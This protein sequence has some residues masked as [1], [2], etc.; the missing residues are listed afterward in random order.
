MQGNPNTGN[1]AA[2]L[3][4]NRDSYQCPSGTSFL[5][6]PTPSEAY[7]NPNRNMNMIKMMGDMFLEM[8]DKIMNMNMNYYSTAPFNEYSQLRKSTITRRGFTYEI[9]SRNCDKEN[10]L[11][12]VNILNMRNNSL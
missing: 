6:G 3:N 5:V 8:S 12:I 1:P 2:W 11:A 10:F 7:M 4:N 9:H